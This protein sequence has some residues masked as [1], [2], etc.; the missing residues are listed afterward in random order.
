MS[1]PQGQH[2]RI[3]RQGVSW[4][5]PRSPVRKRR[6]GARAYRSAGTGDGRGRMFAARHRPCR[7]ASHMSANFSQRPGR[8]MVSKGSWASAQAGNA[9]RANRGAHPERHPPRRLVE[10]PH[11]TG[12][13]VPV[14]VRTD[15]LRRTGHVGLTVLAQ[16]YVVAR[17]LGNRIPVHLHLG[18]RRHPRLTQHAGARRRRAAP[19]HRGGTHRRARRGLQRRA[20]AGYSEAWRRISQT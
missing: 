18:P 2:N 10:P 9:G 7:R 4:R 14:A 15:A 12:A 17:C 20:R 16:L 5:S 1:P 3:R 13:R 19:W 6:T 11:R 8:T